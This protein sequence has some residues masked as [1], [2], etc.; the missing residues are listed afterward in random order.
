MRSLVFGV[1]LFPTL[2]VRY[3]PLGFSPGYLLLGVCLLFVSAS[4]LSAKSLSIS[5]LFLRAN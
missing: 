3:E 5:H 4:F 1:L 2:S